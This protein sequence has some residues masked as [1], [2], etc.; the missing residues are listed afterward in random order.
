MVDPY[1]LPDYLG[2]YIP[3]L[4]ELKKYDENGDGLYSMEEFEAALGI[5]PP[6]TPKPPEKGILI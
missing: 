3:D 1:D 6:S 4:E 5:K 2:P